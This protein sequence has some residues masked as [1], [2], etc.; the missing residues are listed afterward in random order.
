MSGKT[1]A[2]SPPGWGGQ[3]DPGREEV[4][5]YRYQTAKVA[6]VPVTGSADSRLVWFYCPNCDT[7]DGSRIF[8]VELEVVAP[9]EE[10]LDT[11]AFQKRRRTIERVLTRI[12]RD[13]AEQLLAAFSRKDNAGILTDICRAPEDPTR[14]L[15]DPSAARTRSGS[16]EE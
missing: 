10:E 4:P 5:I 2:S 12:T 11:I 13:Q 16:E 3:S 7:T 9:G 14:R 8:E 1:P 6:E 15:Y